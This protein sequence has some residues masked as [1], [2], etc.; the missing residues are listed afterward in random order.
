MKAAGGHG[1]QNITGLN[2]IRTQE[3]LRI[4]GAGSSPGDIKLIWRQKIW[5]FS[6]L[7]ADQ[8]L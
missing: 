4:D 2:S 8:C 6:S 7:A 1:D 3:V 5:V